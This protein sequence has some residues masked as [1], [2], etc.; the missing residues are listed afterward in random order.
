MNWPDGETNKILKDFS[1]R[2]PAGRPDPRPE[3]VPLLYRDIAEQLVRISDW[4]VAQHKQ[5]VNI[6][7][8]LWVLAVVASTLLLRLVPQA[9]N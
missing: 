1:G 9:W 4:Q 6:S 7:R 8:A 5:L 2:F 3:Q